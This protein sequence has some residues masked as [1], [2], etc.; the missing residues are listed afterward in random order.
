MNGPSTL[1]GNFCAKCKLFTFGA[2]S[3]IKPPTPPRRL[4]GWHERPHGRSDPMFSDLDSRGRFSIATGETPHRRQNIRLAQRSCARGLVRR[5][6]RLF[7]DWSRSIIAR[8]IE[9]GCRRSP[10]L[11]FGAWPLQGIEQ[12]RFT[13]WIRNDG[14]WFAVDN[15]TMCVKALAQS[16]S[17]G[18][19]DSIRD[20]GES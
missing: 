16:V 8:P 1:R 20:A 2:S 7:A 19:A 10:P 14:K 5:E 13:T 18:T 11:A 3:P 9:N 17:D 6:V 12:P 15:K 4:D